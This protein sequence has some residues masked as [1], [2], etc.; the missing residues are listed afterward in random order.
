MPVIDANASVDPRAE[1]AADVEIGPYCVVGPHVRLSAG[2]RLESHVHL[3]GHTTIG[4]RTRIY[5][6]ASLG[7]PPQSVKYRGGPTRLV[8]GNDCD[9]RQ[10]VTINTGTEDAGGL[11]TVGDRCFLMAASHVGHDCHVGNH[12]TMANNVLLGGHVEVGD[13]VVLGGLCTV[14]QFVRIGESAMVAGFSG[15]SFDLIPFGLARGRIAILNGLNVVGMRR[16]GLPRE[17][18]HRI[19]R[20]YR[21]L[22]LGEGTFEGRLSTLD[23]EFAE[24]ESAQKIL[25]FIRAGGKRP[26]LSKTKEAATE[27]DETG[28]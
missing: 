6:F 4:E 7:T 18:I 24:D 2:V 22:F 16:R 26:L 11:T 25:T 17:V 8:I 15:L 10:Y 19:R 27:P 14:H 23:P 20:L 12:V 21:H 13:H 28:P 3:T 5:P 9:I 1:I